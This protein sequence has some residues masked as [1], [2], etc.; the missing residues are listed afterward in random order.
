MDVTNDVIYLGVTII[1]FVLSFGFLTVIGRMLN[2]PKEE[3][4]R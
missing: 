3:R 1:F 4:K 2:E